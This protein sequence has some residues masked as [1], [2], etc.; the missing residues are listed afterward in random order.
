MDGFVG[1]DGELSKLDYV[2]SEAA[3]GA[4]R[5]ALV[6]GEPGIGKSRLAQELARLAEARGFGVVWGRSWEAEGTPAYWPWIEALCALESSPAFHEVVTSVRA[7]APEL[8]TLLGG[9]AGPSAGADTKR[10]AFQL[11]A[12]VVRLLGAASALSPILLL[13]D[14]L[15]V[16]DSPSL[17]LLAFVARRLPSTKVLCVGTTRDAPSISSPETTDKLSSLG[18]EAT[19]IA[20]SGLSREV[21]L[22][23]VERESPALALQ[24]ERVFE[25]SAG[26]PLFVREL[27]SSWRADSDGRALPLGVRGAIRAHLQRVSPETLR[28]LT[29]AS[30]LGRDVRTDLL[31][32]IYNGED[33]SSRLEEARAASILA[34]ANDGHTRFTHALVRD[35]LYAGLAA[36]ERASLHRAV[37]RRLAPTERTGALATEDQAES[38]AH[39]ALLAADADGAAWTM[40]VVLAG[41]AAATSKLAFSQACAL[42]TRAQS[43]LESWL[44]PRDEAALLVALGEAQIHAGMRE[45]GQRTC[46]LAADRAEAANDAAL[47]S[48]AALAFAI[49]QRF[50]RQPAA[51]ALLRR[52]RAL[53]GDGEPQL[54]AVVLAR[55]ATAMVPP[56]PEE[57]DEPLALARSALS[58]AREHGN[59]ETRL[60]VF[61]MLATVFPEEFPLS[62]RFSLNAEAIALAEKLGQVASVSLLFGWQIACWLEL[63]RLDGARQELAFAEKRFAALPE[64]YQWRPSLLRAL[65]AALDGRWDEANA[66]GR[67]VLRS[68]GEGAMFAS[69]QQM[70][71]PYLRGDADGFAEVDAEIARIHAVIPGSKVFL[72][73]GDAVRG[74]VEQV[75]AKLSAAREMDL[76]GVPGVEQLGWPV[77]RSGLTDLAPF[78]YD[79]A[80][81]RTKSPLSFGPAATSTMG[82]RE[83]LAG[84]LAHLA[85]KLDAA[86]EHLE[87][88]L[89]F[90][91][92][93]GS[94]PLIAQT[95]LALA[96]VLTSKRSPEARVHAQ[97]A[98]EIAEPL[99]MRT[100]AAR[101]RE[102]ASSAPLSV[103]PPPL[104]A[105]STQALSLRR[106]GELWA[107]TVGPCE[108]L[109]KDARGLAYLDALVSA[110][111]MEVH[112]LELLGVGDHGDAGPVLDETAKRAYKQRATEL[113][114][115]LDLATRFSD[116]GRIEKARA[117]LDALGEELSRAV[118][119]GGRDK[120]AA[121]A[122]EKARINVQRRLRDVIRRATEADE[123]IGMHL[124]ASVKTG[125]F[126]RYAPTWPP[127][128]R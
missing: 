77:V 76:S 13:L 34:S 121:S 119:L 63:G 61:T 36:A 53:L 33:L 102:L 123:K 79:L 19:Q 104:V 83:L 31:R 96:E 111:H 99:S 24:A 3:L 23:W 68:G 71:M 126:C 7:S 105:P 45:Q 44:T 12:S 118:G 35:E 94:G 40:S 16:A 59:D 110:P 10:A 67:R 91:M 39:H 51:M 52:A 60:S 128:E 78:Y 64:Y 74:Q 22:A 43:A 17:E 81:S 116:R 5:L 11:G 15:H 46:A 26:N 70:V 98:L 95:E 86:Q 125:V 85:G 14:D 97:A 8:D 122:A 55:L 92:Q 21:V 18:S 50:G 89:V 57:K 114:A 56:L 65:I 84:R 112:V 69:I 6:S 90:C 28:V 38:A 54:R 73:I 107:I 20:L 82:P 100:V 115:E 49:E 4:G 30:V 87:H 2:L 42:G 41:M 47:L 29:V 32:A 27:L 108:I 103:R 117:E 58:L 101:A 48:R 88:S 80:C 106:R 120:R 127:T 75:R 25:G 37:A 9:R 62:E 113:R 66:I 109:L 124:E 1:R 72:S 93:L